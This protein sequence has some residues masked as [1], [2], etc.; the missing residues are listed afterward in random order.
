MEDPPRCVGICECSLTGWGGMKA[1]PSPLKEPPA[2]LTRAFDYVV[3]R[4]ARPPTAADQ[5][6]TFNWNS[7]CRLSKSVRLCVPYVFALLV[8]YPSDI[9]LVL[10][11]LNSVLLPKSVA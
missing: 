7:I 1:Y 6:L 4:S 8:G 3:P 11:G 10:L 9:L 2:P 5:N